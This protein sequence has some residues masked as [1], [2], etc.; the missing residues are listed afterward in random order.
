[1]NLSLKSSLGPLLLLLAFQLLFW[2]QWLGV[3]ALLFTML[4]FGFLLAS[5]SS[6]LSSWSVRL[7][8][9]VTLLLGAFVLWHGGHWAKVLW[10]IS[11]PTALGFARNPDM[12]HPLST[13]WGFGVGSLK[14]MPYWGRFFKKEVSTDVD[15]EGENP[16]NIN[17]GIYLLS[18]AI[19]FIF[20]GI[21]SLASN[22]FAEWIGNAFEA[23]GDMF[24]G[25]SFDWIPFI[26][27]GLLLIGGAVWGVVQVKGRGWLSD[28][29]SVRMPLPEGLS[30]SDISKLQLS[31]ATLVPL[32]LILLL[33]NV[34]DV[35]QV[36]IVDKA[37]LPENLSQ[38]VHEG[39]YIL[40]FS[41]LLAVI[42]VLAIVPKAAS[43]NENY[44]FLQLLI[45]A[46]LFQNA[47]LVISVAIRNVHYINHSG[48]AFK[49]IGVFFFLVLVVIG[50]ISVW[51]KINQRRNA[52]WVFWVNSWAVYL[53]LT[54]SAVVNWSVVVTRYN[55]EV[56]QRGN[57]DYT[58]LFYEVGPDNL[59]VLLENMDRLGNISVERD[60]YSG[61]QPLDA[62]MVLTERVKEFIHLHQYHPGWPSWNGTYQRNLDAAN[63]YFAQITKQ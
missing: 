62:K 54:C 10:M 53:V 6:I 50:L 25:F 26:L 14:A 60:S 56:H 30:G 18:F 49:R 15:L 7:S 13:F 47:F 27:L 16:K 58:F 61:Y 22:R 32:N 34:S 38:F 51:V 23:V 57:L 3:N 36:W 37:L 24:T 1:M 11:L 39:T 4:I 12:L 40:I 19:C 52:A 59:Y 42:V 28:T 33:L 29:V 21:Y 63:A 9:V 48:L 31:F 2:H 55:L 35:T 45:G 43:L 17:W 20:I 44:R 41:I 8:M 46:W 5:D